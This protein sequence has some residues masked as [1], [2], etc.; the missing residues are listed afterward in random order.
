LNNSSKSN[1]I[2]PYDNI[3]PIRQQKESKIDFSRSIANPRKDKRTNRDHSRQF[4]SA[5]TKRFFIILIPIIALL[6]IGLAAM[7][8]GIFATGKTTTS[9]TVTTTTRTSKYKTVKLKKNSF[10][11]S[12]I[13]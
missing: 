3:V 13:L 9:T 8:V 5:C 7:F 2:F 4:C 1:L 11:S 12:L 6:L 10:I